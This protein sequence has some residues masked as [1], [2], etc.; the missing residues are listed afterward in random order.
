MLATNEY[1]II[2]RYREGVNI[3]GYALKDQNGNTLKLSKGDTEKLALNKQIKNC[4]AQKS[5]GLVIMK[6]VGCQLKNITTYT[7]GKKQEEEKGEIVAKITDGRNA[8]SYIIA[9]KNGN[10]VTLSREETIV[11]ARNN[12]LSNAKAQVSN[13]ELVLRGDKGSNLSQLPSYDMSKRGI[14]A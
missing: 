10:K 7:I 5:N 3:V 9:Y 4:T 11:M 6:G 8:N 1:I 2:A 14:Y 13:G 12:K